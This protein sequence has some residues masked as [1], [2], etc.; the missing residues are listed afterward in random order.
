MNFPV[1]LA[2]QSDQV[3]R[4]ILAL[5]APESLMMNFNCGKR[6]AGLAPPAVAL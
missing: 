2:T 5:M 3:V 1:T 4:D 6:A